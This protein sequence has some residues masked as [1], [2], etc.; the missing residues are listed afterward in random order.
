MPKTIRPLFVCL[1]WMVFPFWLYAQDGRAVDWWEMGDGGEAVSLQNLSFE[2]SETP[3]SDLFVGWMAASEV[4]TDL[5]LSGKASVGRTAGNDALWTRPGPGIVDTVPHPK[6][7][8]PA[9]EWRKTLTFAQR[10]SGAFRSKK[11]GGVRSPGMAALCSILVPGLGQC[12]NAQWYKPP[13]IY[14]GAAVIGYF[15][16]F[17][18]KEKRVYEKEIWARYEQDTLALNPNLVNK[19]KDQLLS[20]RNYYQQ[21]FELTLII[22]GAV[23]LL[24]IIDA[25]VYAY[26]FDF[27][28]SPNLALVV[29]PYARPNYD[30]KNGTF[31]LD[32][33]FRLCM[34]FK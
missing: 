1:L 28:V 31:P 22:A 20:L 18:L 33:G 23:Y 30:P 26:L 5:N 10:N 11:H 16:D 8:L 17:N 19:S 21:N 29:E 7:T 15:V 2:R 6:N 24:N 34:T 13:V 32:M 12:Y 3:I 25:V 9:K 4:W 27:N 14:A